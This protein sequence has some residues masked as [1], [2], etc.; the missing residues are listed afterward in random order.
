MYLQK[1]VCMKDF[2]YPTEMQSSLHQ[3]KTI[4][5][6]CT[7]EDATEK[8]KASGSRKADHNSLS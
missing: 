2:L 7:T 1:W 8:I 4:H 5:Q 3:D 6:L